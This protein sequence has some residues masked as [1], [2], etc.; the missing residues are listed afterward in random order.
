MCRARACSRWQAQVQA[1]NRKKLRALEERHL[2]QQTVV[3]YNAL[4]ALAVADGHVSPQERA[5]AS[6]LEA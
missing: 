6:L 4:V 3:T 5:G 1:R 2:R